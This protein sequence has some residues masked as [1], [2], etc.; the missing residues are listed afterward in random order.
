MAGREKS[1]WLSGNGYNSPW[2]YVHVKD[3]PSL[4]VEGEYTIS[5][6]IYRKNA[7]GD[8]RNLYD[9]PDAHLFEFSPSG[10]FDWRSENNNI[11]FNVNGPQISEGAWTHVA[12]TMTELSDGSHQADVYVDGV[13]ASGGSS[14]QLGQRNNQTGVRDSDQDL[15]IGVLWS[16][17]NGNADPWA[18]GIDDFKIWN[19]SLNA[20]QIKRVYE[21]KNVQRSAMVAEYTFDNDSG[22]TVLDSSGNNNHGT[23]VNTANPPAAPKPPSESPAGGNLLNFS[24]NGY[25]SPWEYVHV[26]DSPSLSVEGEYTISSWIYR[27]NAGGDWRN[28]YDIPDAHLFEFSPSGGFDWRSLENNNIDFNVNGPLISEGAWT[29]CSSDDD[30]VVRW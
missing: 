26:K 1:L 18:G 19:K 23:L 17:R 21:G 28:L 27:K 11:D 14:W 25:N 5:S 10:G 6:W 4:S 22:S 30:G 12:A 24:G 16:Q 13:L 29:H 15:Y 9:I 2:E 3:S 7:G 20:A 8:W